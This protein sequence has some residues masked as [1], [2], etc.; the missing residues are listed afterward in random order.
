MFAKNVQWTALLL[1]AFAALAFTSCLRQEEIAGGEEIVTT[2]G[3]NVPEVFRTRTA[4][5]TVYEES[6]AHYLGNSGMPSIGNVDLKEHPLTFTV[7]IYVKKAQAA[8]EAPS[9][10]LVDKQ[11]HTV[12]DD[13]AYF[14]FRL[15]KDQKYHLVAYAD[16]SGAGKDDLEAIPYTTGLNDELSDAF[17]ASEDFYARENVEV[18]LKRP[19]G[20]LRLIAHD[21]NTFAA[22][23]AFKITKVKVAYRRAPM[24]ATDK[25]NALTGDFN[26]DENANGN[27]TVEADP[28]VYT[29]EYTADGKAPVVD[30]KEGPV[31]VFT[32]YLPANFGEGGS[33]EDTPG[34]LIP[35]PDHVG[36]IPQS[37]FYPFD[38]TVEYEGANDAAVNGTITRSY[39]IDIPVKR[40]WLTTVDAT[41]FWTGK[42]G[43]MVTV[44]AAF[45]GEIKI[46]D[47]EQATVNN[48]NDL[49]MAI[50][51]IFRDA[52]DGKISEYTIV[53]GQDIDATD[54][55]GFEFSNLKADGK[56]RSNR[57]VK[58]HLDLNGHTITTDGTRYPTYIDDAGVAR[59]TVG[60]L[61]HVQGVNCHLYIDDTNK[62]QVG[63]LKFVGDA[64]TAYPLV[65]CHNGG[66]ATIN[67]GNFITSSPSEAIYVYESEAHRFMVQQWVLNSLR[68]KK[69]DK[70]AQ[71]PTDAETLA[72]IESNVKKWS[73][74]VTINGGW[75]ESAID[76]TT[77]DK[78]RVVVNAYNA[79]ESRWDYYKNVLPDNGYPDWTS[80]GEYVNQIFGFVHVNGGSF[81]EFDPSKGDNIVGN[82]PNEWVGNGHVQTEIVNSKTVYTVIPEDEVHDF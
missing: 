36:D 53:L 69:G 77:E 49:Q 52:P 24:L 57:I 54:R 23:G 30:G 61:F 59:M 75:Y 8:G 1:S 78:Y 25:F 17:F 7:G 28:V 62:D 81:V 51:E 74:S 79:R 37:Y 64:A 82:M 56:D 13:N 14:E 42:S 41:H 15:L 80:W 33:L 11:V 32:M 31:A 68:I 70:D 65:C 12:E 2:V 76:A 55:V 46:G 35:D 34:Q 26:Y 4:T 29:K 60:G 6:S 9:Y 72:K 45:E 66:Q 48:A 21:F 27:H 19:F 22:G 16:F 58:I 40:N 47:E 67:R 44:H 20:K 71:K 50:D 3:V 63:G 73:A 5:Q 10:A 43:V 39:T 38:V 18:V